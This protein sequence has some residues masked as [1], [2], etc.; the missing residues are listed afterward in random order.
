[1]RVL[2]PQLE[3][4]AASAAAL[5][6]AVL[7]GVALHAAA[8]T[9]PLYAIIGLLLAAVA[10]GLAARFR[11]PVGRS[12][13]AENRLRLLESAVIH[14]HDAVVVLDAEVQTGLGRSVLYANDAFYKMTGYGRDEVV[15]RSLHFLRG[16]GSDP[17]TLNQIR[18]ALGAGQPLRVEL[19]NYRKDGTPFWVDLSLVPVPDPNGGAAHWVMIQRDITDRK[20]AEDALQRSEGLFRGIF[21]NTSAGVS[22]IDPSGRFVSC[23][24]AFAAMTGRTVEELLTLTPESIAHPD[25]WAA[26]VPLM[27]EI[28]AGMRDRFHLPNRYVWPTGEV[29]WVELSYVAVWGPTGEFEYGLGV[30]LNVNERRRLEDQLRQAQKMDAIGQMAG[31]V[32]HD[33]NNLLTAVL[34]NLALVNLP[35]SDPN[36]AMLATVEQAAVRAADLTGKLLG[37]AR[38]NQLVFAP[39]K[40]ADAFDEVIG[41]L[42]RTLDPRV[43][44][45]VQVADD[46]DPVHADPTLLT[47]ALMN[48]CL[49]S[50]DAMPEG[51]TLTLTAAV[52]EVS[53]VDEGRYPGDSRPG[54]FVRLT[55]SD[56][57][58]GMANEV[59]ARI[60]EPFFTTKG[61]GKGTGLGLPMVQGI[62]KQHQGWVTCDSAPGAGTRLDL[63][64]PPADPNTVSRSIL[65]S[66]ASAP[67]SPPQTD[68]SRTPLPRPAQPIVSEE[69]IADP[70]PTV[71]DLK[72][73]ILLVDDESM[74]RQLGQVVL[75][76]AGFSVLTADDGVEAVDVFG[77][78]HNRIDLVILDVTMPRMSGRDAFR[79]LLGIDPTARILFS[80]GYSDEH[81]AELDG[82]VG[83]L[84]KPYR[85]HELLT[86]VQSALETQPAAG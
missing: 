86:A 9:F 77:R 57:G 29:L 48:L 56:T 20:R 6:T 81:I 37:Y 10:G 16:P 19:Q 59:Q 4:V 33:F 32:A 22:L 51:G 44:L 3:T 74:I 82:A 63:Y 39:I 46:C 25:D 75:D 49:N 14:A 42:H 72:P 61:Q 79:H 2:T 60:F 17:S 38:R 12:R 18:V 8:P 66:P 5:G 27:A 47:Q 45:V 54:R 28:R 50:R 7:A 30:S 11:L 80:T 71:S 40:P 84:S 85:P 23:N 64:L 78:E 68:V 69:L 24:P 1:M 41:L 53:A 43:R 67:S 58:V 70:E 65:R 34:G 55:V 76:R 13:I 21:E 62:V 35:E 26:Q 15:G 83:L 73:T 52:V 31:G 36:R